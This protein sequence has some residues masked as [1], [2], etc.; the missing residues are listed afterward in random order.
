VSERLPEIKYN[1][2]R[3]MTEW[4]DD[5]LVRIAA[6]S[7]PS[8]D[9]HPEEWAIGWLDAKMDG[10]SEWIFEPQEG[11]RKEWYVTH[12]LPLPPKPE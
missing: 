5:V 7:W 11:E 1:A 2:V 9:P 12:W 10:T 4:S 8:G 6:R 3:N